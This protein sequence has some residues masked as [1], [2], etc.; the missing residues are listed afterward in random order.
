MNRVMR[1]TMGDCSTLEE[2]R[3][4]VRCQECGRTWRSSTVRFSK[5]GIAPTT[6]HWRVILR[7]LYERERE[8][9]R[10]KAMAEVPAIYNRCPVCGRLVCDRCFLICEDLDMCVACAGRL[11][12]RGDIV[13][14][15]VIP[16]EPPA[17]EENPEV[18]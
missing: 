5:A 9:A 11:Q 17:E 8:A 4:L 16:Q 13:A 2:F 14:E 7:T 18:M 10:E 12:V 15:N 1:E 3:F 6:E